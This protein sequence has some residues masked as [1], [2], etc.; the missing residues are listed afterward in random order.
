MSL[1]LDVMLRSSGILVAALVALAF[2]RRRSAALRHS[3]LA[4][5]MAA[6]AVVLPLSWVLPV[7]TV[8]VPAAMSAPVS[9]PLETPAV[10][11]P[12]PVDAAE[13]AQRPTLTT[14][15]V[16]G[17]AI[18]VVV[19]AVMLALAFARLR[20]IDLRAVPVLD[21]PWSRGAADLAARVGLRRSITLLQTDAPDV[22]ATW[23]LIRPRILLPSH[24]HHWSPPRIHAVLGHEVAHIQRH[25]WVVQIAAEAVRAVYWF[26]P[27]FW[28]A[29]RR[30]RRE[31]EQACDD[32]VLSIGVPPRDYAMHLLRVARS[33]RT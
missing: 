13:S 8:Q 22:L 20:R 24:A 18:G 31:S 30:L 29:C 32:A 4:G 6:S 17:W 27:V 12:T 1:L 25:D 15:V 14:L 19:G 10:A 9:A 26:N 3:V 2:M 23:G 33:W 5:A 16:T 7:W 28:L 11:D 21:G